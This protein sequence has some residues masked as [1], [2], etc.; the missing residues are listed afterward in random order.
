MYFTTNKFQTI[1]QNI[2][3]YEIFFVSLHRKCK[4][5]MVEFDF[6]TDA[7]REKAKKDIEEIVNNEDKTELIE[8][9]FG[10]M[11]FIAKHEVNF[12][13]IKAVL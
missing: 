4:I 9:L 10:M 5:T 13:N 11:D 1:L 6:T 8:L 7:G 3:L 12:E 2:W